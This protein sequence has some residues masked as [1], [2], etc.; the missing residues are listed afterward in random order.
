[1]KIKII[2]NQ[3]KDVYIYIY[4]NIWNI[5]WH[6]FVFYNLKNQLKSKYIFNSMKLINKLNMLYLSYL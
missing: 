3:M 2:I 1:M 5:Y 4:F 6:L